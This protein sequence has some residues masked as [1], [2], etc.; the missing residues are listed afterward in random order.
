[1]DERNRAI[2]LFFVLF[3]VL[4]KPAANQPLLDVCATCHT[5]ATCEEKTDGSGKVCNCKYGFVGNGRTF[6]QDK[7]EC[8]IGSSKICGQHTTCHNTYGSYYCTCLAGY[9]PSN[10]LDVF[11]PNDGTHCQDIDECRVAGQCGEGGECRNLDG[12]F[13]C[14]CQE[15]YRVHNGA[16]PFHPPTDHALCKVVDCGA[17]AAVEDTVQ[18]SLTGTT[19][20]SVAT[21]VCDEGF[22]WRRGH[23]SSV[24][25]ANGLWRGLTL[26][27]E[28]KCGPIP[29]L[30]NSEVV[31]HNRSV[32]IHR[33]M[34]GY[35]SWRGSNASLCNS[36][37]VWETATLRCVEIKPPINHLLIHYERCLHWKAEKYEE[38]TEDYKVTYSGSR[39]YQTL[40]RDKGKRFLSSKADQLTLCLKLLP[41]TNYSITI[42]ALSAKF[43]ATITTNTSLPV[44]PAPVVYYMEVETPAPTL[45][46][47]RSPNTLDPLSLYQ[48]FVLPVE[49]IMM[50]DCSSPR[51]L[52]PSVK[53]KSSEEYITAQLSVRNIGTHINFTVGD[54]FFY[55][56]FHNALLE[57]G[58]NYYIILRAV[59]Q[60]KTDSKSSCVLWA[61]VT[62]TPYVLSI[63]LVS[64]A[65]LVAVVIL[66]AVGGYSVIW[67]IKKIR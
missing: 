14:S 39:D 60:W 19:Y 27:C 61:K 3:V 53:I 21:F 7:D 5:D 42:T 57:S 32:V 67:C 25:A 66:A 26:V 4:G 54:G 30:A 31:W 55:G 44:P 37:G 12:S 36:S 51:S 48:V 28:A 63:S 50:F 38:D 17:P 34:A 15:G 29:F 8:Q 58:K 56:G 41:V 33:C 45:Q 9:S 16:Q 47:Q 49:G 35:H 6:C 52:D 18:V 22:V 24:C 23:N 43:S 1:M 10:N 65:L 11:I 64:A 59:S 2:F 13:D 62:G 46:L 20:G 40:F